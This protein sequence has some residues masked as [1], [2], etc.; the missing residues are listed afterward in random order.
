M[1]SAVLQ[2][3]KEIAAYVGR[4][5]R[6]VQRWEAFG[7]PVRR[8][9]GRNRS[10]VLA[11]KDEVDQWLRTCARHELPGAI[12]RRSGFVLERRSGKERRSRTRAAGSSELN[13][14]P[15]ARRVDGNNAA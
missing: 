4:G 10:A 9:S 1:G 3:W 13:V 15:M 7:L 5:V 14:E 2:S 12:E 11:L 8:P 6:T